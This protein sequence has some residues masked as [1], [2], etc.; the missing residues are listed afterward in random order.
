MHAF[1][2]KAWRPTRVVVDSQA[3]HDA[4]VLT[5]IQVADLFDFFL[6]I[7]TVILV[8]DHWIN[9]LFIFTTILVAD[10]SIIFFV[11]FYRYS[12]G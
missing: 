8:A 1:Q 2:E 10:H 12:G 6:F 11:Y 9:F 5:A 7:F 4:H 3:G